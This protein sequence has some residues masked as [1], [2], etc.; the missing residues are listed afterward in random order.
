[1]EV[2]DRLTEERREQLVDVLDWPKTSNIQRSLA[3]WPCYNVL[4][5]L[6][7]STRLCDAC[8]RSKVHA[9]IILYGQPYNATTLD[10]AS[11]TSNSEKVSAT[12]NYALTRVICVRMFP[13]GPI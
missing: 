9:R 7:V 3:T 8:E 12:L 4:A 6:K 1:M 5:D 2:I 10:G 13:L 11:P